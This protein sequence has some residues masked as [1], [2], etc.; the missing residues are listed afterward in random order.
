MGEAV[1]DYG[2][3]YNGEAEDTQEGVDQ[4]DIPI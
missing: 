4:T 2:M 1:S 3:G